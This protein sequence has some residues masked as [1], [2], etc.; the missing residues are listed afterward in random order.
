MYEYCVVVGWGVVCRASQGGAVVSCEAAGCRQHSGEGR[1]A[2]PTLQEGSFVCGIPVASNGSTWR[3][4]ITNEVIN[5][6]LFV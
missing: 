1:D 5:T 3:L 6:S 4:S 2:C